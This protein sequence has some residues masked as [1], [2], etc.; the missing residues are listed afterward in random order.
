[1]QLRI[2]HIDP[3]PDRD[4]LTI[5]HITFS[6]PDTE[7]EPRSMLREQQYMRPEGG[8]LA[9]GETALWC[10]GSVWTADEQRAYN[11]IYL[12]SPAPPRLRVNVNC[13]GIEEPY[14]QAWD[15]IPWTDPTGEGPLLLPFALRDLADDEY[16]V[17]DATHWFNGQEKGT[18]IFAHDIDIQARV[19]G[20]WTRTYSGEASENGDIRIFGRP[21]RAMADGDVFKVVD[22]NPDRAFGNDDSGPEANYVWVRHRDLEVKYTHLR[23]GSIIAFEGQEVKAGQQL[24]EGGNSGRTSGMPHL[25][26]E[27]RLASSD[28][29]CPMTFHKA[30]QLARDLVPETGN[31]RRVSLA[32]RGICEE[33]AAIRP[34]AAGRFRAARESD[35]GLQKAP[36]TAARSRPRARTAGRAKPR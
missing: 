15:L 7:L 4:T 34:F 27:C 13:D 26:I 12:D 36:S 17:T 14:T 8:V 20:R 31:G 16:V 23:N 6:F 1:V 28:T 33:K 19:D 11:Q 3:D 25:H 30:W 21:V 32:G 9:R 18:Q 24:A 5:E 29:L 22:G 35:L 10:N 2:T